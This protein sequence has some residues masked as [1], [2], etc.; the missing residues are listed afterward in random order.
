MPRNGG[1][2][3]HSKQNV[4]SWKRLTRHILRKIHDGNWIQWHAPIS[5]H[6]VTESIASNRDKGERKTQVHSYTIRVMLTIGTNRVY[7]ELCWIEHIVYLLVSHTSQTNVTNWRQQSTP[8]TS[9][10]LPSKV[11][12]T[13]RFVT[14][15]DL[16]HKLKR[17]MTRFEWFYHL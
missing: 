17:Q 10:T 12:W 8:N 7:W 16:Y 4:T 14:S 2:P 6:P 15:S 1:I 3:L 11:S 13:Q 9:L 5:V